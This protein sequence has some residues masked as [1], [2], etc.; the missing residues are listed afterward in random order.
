MEVVHFKKTPLLR[1]Y[2]ALRT[3]V[4]GKGEEETKRRT[5]DWSLITDRM[6]SIMC[7]KVVCSVIYHT[8]PRV[9]RTRG[10]RF[11][12]SGIQII[13]LCVFTPT[14]VEKGRKVNV[15]NLV[16]AWQKQYGKK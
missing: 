12:Q 3:I 9:A 13:G 4:E 15:A 16:D 1:T 14:L 5:A 6:E 10:C 8:S 11:I 2:I 7:L